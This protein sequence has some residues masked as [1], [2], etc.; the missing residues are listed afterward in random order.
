MQQISMAALNRKLNRAVGRQAISGLII[1]GDLTEFGHNDEL[2]R[3]KT[4]WT[5]TKFDNVIKVYPGLG[6]HDYAN[7][8]GECTLDHCVNR[9]LRWFRSF[10]KGK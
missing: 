10:V 1:N 7:N 2:T 8:V 3:L 9:M 5:S 4:L 6:N